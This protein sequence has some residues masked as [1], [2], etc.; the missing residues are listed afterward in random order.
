L[1]LEWKDR[2]AQRE[3]ALVAPKSKVE[4]FAAICRDSRTEGLAV[5]FGAQV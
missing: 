4:L 5:R 2:G 3:G 1:I